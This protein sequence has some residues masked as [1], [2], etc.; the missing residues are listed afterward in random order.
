MTKRSHGEA[1]PVN[2]YQQLIAAGI[3]VA[4]SIFREIER[5]Q[6]ELNV[7]QMLGLMGNG[8]KTA[9]E[10]CSPNENKMDS[11]HSGVTQISIHIPASLKP[12][13]KK[14]GS[15]KMRETYTT[16]PLILPEGL[17]GLQTLCRIGDMGNF[18]V[19]GSALSTTTYNSPYNY[20]AMNPDAQMT[21]SDLYTKTPTDILIDTANNRINLDHAEISITVKN[22]TTT[23]ATYVDIYVVEAKRNIEKNSVTAA[24][25]YAQKDALDVWQSALFTQSSGL[26]NQ[27]VSTGT[28]VPGVEISAQVGA[29]PQDAQ[30]FLDQYKIKS[31]H[32]INLE[33]G[34]EETI[35]YN[36]P[37]HMSLNGNKLIQ[38][39][40]YGSAITAHTVGNNANLNQIRI[41]SLAHGLEFFVIAHGGLIKNSV[42]QV[43]SYG[44]A[45]LGFVIQ[46]KIKLSA[47]INHTSQQKTVLAQNTLETGALSTNLTAPDMNDQVNPV[48]VT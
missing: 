42:T 5:L 24:N 4:P 47:P 33:S 23:I 19:L 14:T 48:K 43:V 32:H 29:R 11:L 2:F 27:Q 9:T 22:L 20:F 8:S 34:S 17:Q 6:V 38:E 21:G 7:G 1:F 28:Q 46:R 3:S 12:N 45:E 25:Q 26:P 10:E 30:G 39:N 40:N 31:V 16:A 15:F 35:N 18:L 44:L 41:G 13:R 36:C 37:L